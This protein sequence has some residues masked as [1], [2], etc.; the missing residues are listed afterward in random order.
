MLLKRSAILLLF[1]IELRVVANIVLSFFASNLATG[2][3]STSLKLVIK[4]LT[5]VR[6]LLKLCVEPFVINI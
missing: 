3:K 5:F 4:L 6:I 2:F 1:N